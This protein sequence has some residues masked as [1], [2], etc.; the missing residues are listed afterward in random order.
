MVPRLAPR[1]APRTAER[2]WS[3]LGFTM[4]LMVTLALVL[5]VRVPSSPSGVEEQEAATAAFLAS[6]VVAVDLSAPPTREELAV[7]DGRGTVYHRN[8]DDS[9]FS[10]DVAMA[11]GKV[12]RLTATLVAVTTRD[13]GEPVEML[14]A[15]NDLTFAQLREVLDVAVTEW[16]VDE[17]WARTAVSDARRA[18]RRGEIF[19]EHLGAQAVEP[20]EFVSFD[21]SVNEGTLSLQVRIAWTPPT[22]GEGVTPIT[23]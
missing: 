18:V 11:D 19:V 12:L 21:P 13:G 14:V 2:V 17:T 8:P 4:L 16:G 7:A 1:L 10:V 3:R 23:Q 22:L 5:A 15:R 9:P 20:P 6:G